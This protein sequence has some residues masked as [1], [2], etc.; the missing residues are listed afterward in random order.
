MS[1]IDRAPYLQ[2][3]CAERIARADLLLAD[4]NITAEEHDRRVASAR[5]DLAA[6]LPGP[7]LT[8]EQGTA[9]QSGEQE[10]N[11]PPPTDGAPRFEFGPR[12]GGKRQ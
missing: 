11:P 8:G 10:G 12:P 4:G 3:V 1:S 2:A 6:G 5:A 7:R 9:Q